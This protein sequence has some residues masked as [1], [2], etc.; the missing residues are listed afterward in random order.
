VNKKKELPISDEMLRYLYQERLMST[1]EIA[2]HITNN[3]D[4]SVS[5]NLILRR[6]RELDI[7]RSRSLAARIRVKKHPELLQNLIAQGVERARSDKERKRAS[8]LISTASKEFRRSPQWRSH[9]R[10]LQRSN[11]IKIVNK[12]RRTELNCSLCGK[13][14]VRRSSDMKR[15]FKQH[16][17]EWEHGQELPSDYSPFC[18]TKCRGKHFGYQRSIQASLRKAIAATSP[19]REVTL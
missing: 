9:I 8:L 7:A 19:E 16:G 13:K 18:N 1:T 15:Q 14:V 11:I 2:L 12:T 4:L 10:K 5:N 17:Y 3:F 6:L